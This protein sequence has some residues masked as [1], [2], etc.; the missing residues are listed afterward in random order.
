MIVYFMLKPPPEPISVNE[1]IAGIREL[2]YFDSH[3]DIPKY[4]LDIAK[5]YD[6]SEAW[7]TLWWLGRGH[8]EP[9]TYCNGVVKTWSEFT[10][11]QVMCT[12]TFGTVLPKRRTLP[13]CA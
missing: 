9:F 5:T 4:I 10:L 12:Q 13:H 7:H 3:P 8:T 11:S 1:L 2:L 6:G